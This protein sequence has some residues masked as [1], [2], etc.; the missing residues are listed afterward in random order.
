M[1]VWSPRFRCEIDAL[2]SVRRR[3]IKARELSHIPYEL[4][5][6]KLRIMDF[7]IVNVFKNPNIQNLVN[8]LDEVLNSWLGLRMCLDLITVTFPN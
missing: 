7:Y 6:E 1:Y 8:G 2:E 4:R 5:L 3:P